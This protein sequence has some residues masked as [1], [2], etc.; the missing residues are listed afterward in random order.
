MLALSQMRA[1]EVPN[2]MLLRGRSK[3]RPCRGPAANEIN[4]AFRRHRRNP[5]AS[6]P[7]R[8]LREGMPNAW[9]RDVFG[10]SEQ[11]GRGA[12]RAPEN[13]VVGWDVRGRTE[14]APTGDSTPTKSTA[15]CGMACQ[16]PGPATCSERRNSA[17]GALSER[18]KTLSWAG[19]FAG[20]RSSPLPGTRRQRTQPRV[21]DAARN[22]R[23]LP[24]VQPA[25][26]IIRTA[27]SMKAGA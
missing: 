13:V 5:V 16:T 2:H 14:F 23:N 24:F 26:T 1:P 20:E 9:A 17:V 11:C 22:R 8:A 7:I 10:T 6:E 12:L 4:R 18:P 25:C 3:E 19:T 15:R 21:A 27:N